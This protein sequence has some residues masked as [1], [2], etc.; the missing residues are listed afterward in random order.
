MRRSF[1]FFHKGFV[2]L[3]VVMIVCLLTIMPARAEQCPGPGGVRTKVTKKDFC[4]NGLAYIKVVE[5]F[6][7]PETSASSC[8]DSCYKP[9]CT[10]TKTER[11]PEN[12][13]YCGI[14]SV[15]QPNPDST[16]YNQREW[17][18]PGR[19]FELVTVTGRRGRSFFFKEVLKILI[20]MT[21]KVA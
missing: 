1:L 3:A 9:T 11:A 14:T 17:G 13:Q 4:R 10:R 19:T 15:E 20:R 8:P 2:F 7:M 6:T 12:D 18:N 16:D 21:A 5:K